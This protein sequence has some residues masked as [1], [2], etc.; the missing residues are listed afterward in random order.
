MT[1]ILPTECMLPDAVYEADLKYLSVFA[2][3]HF[4]KVKW[5]VSGLYKMTKFG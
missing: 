5:H 3:V 4:M 1:H 2:V